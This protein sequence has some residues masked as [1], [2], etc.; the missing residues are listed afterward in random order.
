MA[1]IAIPENLRP[2]LGIIAKYHF[3]ILASLVPILL[4]PLLF[5]GAGGLR[6]RIAT[7]RQ[8][9]QSK[10]GQAQSVRN[11]QP[12]PNESWRTAID[13]DVAETD[14][15]TLDEW[16]RFW[17]S[18]SGLWSW[19]AMLGDAFLA[20][21]GRLQPGG[22]LERNS[23][24][25]YRDL[26]PRLVQELPARMGVAN[27]MVEQ[28]NQKAA[29]AA[30]PT[31]VPLAPP[32]SWSQASQKKL[33]DSF[34]W[35]GVP[36]TTQ[37]VLAQ[38]ELHVYGLFCDLIAAFV[39]GATGAHDSPL[40]VVEELAVGFPA[41]EEPQE[42]TRIDVPATPGAVPGQ[43][44]VMMPPA[45][46]DQ[47][48]PRWHPRFARD[49]GGG[50][51]RSG[52]QPRS[53]DNDYRSWIYVTFAGKPLSAAELDADPA[54]R[55]VHLMPFVLRVVIDQRQLDRLLVALAR[56]PIPIDVRQVRVNS[57]KQSGRRPNDI[58]VE[59]RG[60]VALATHPPTAATQP[61]A[62]EAVP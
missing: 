40:T 35:E 28:S 22:R 60:T 15:E 46:P 3:W 9:I 58:V 14:R 53:P 48:Q 30:P 34:V 62:P 17:H 13:A 55:M 47:A 24:L 50:P 23:L 31:G 10:I 42:G 19:P 20:D 6:A 21:A 26:A 2:A 37:V 8:S 29:G 7:Q 33:Q 5:V 43:G 61:P 44:D 16:R 25:R 52:D 38:E 51:A 45:G 59:L 56:S 39:K 54:M 12:H 32:L 27:A 11:Q 1:G 4:L 57:M 49:G 36:N 41:L 18:Q